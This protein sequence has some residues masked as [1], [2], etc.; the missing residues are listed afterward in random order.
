LLEL[1]ASSELILAGGSGRGY[2]GAVL[3][4]DLVGN[5]VIIKAGSGA[6]L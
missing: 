5:S 6:T 3:E 4:V 2:P 1:T